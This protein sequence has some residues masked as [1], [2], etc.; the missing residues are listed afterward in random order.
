MRGF[1]E[2]KLRCYWQCHFY[3][4]P[5]KIVV[6]NITQNPFQLSTLLEGWLIEKL[7][8]NWQC[9]LIQVPHMCH[10]TVVGVLKKSSYSS[11]LHHRLRVDKSDKKQ[12]RSSTQFN[13]SSFL[14]LKQLLTLFILTQK[15]EQQAAN[16][17]SFA[18]K[19]SLKCNK[20]NSCSHVY[21]EGTK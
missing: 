12:E 18:I 20:K 2:R 16:F 10:F 3:F 8:W 14:P 9:E 21:E 6:V 4:L 5:K 1:L 15:T 17:M 19:R 11:F 13:C 7:K